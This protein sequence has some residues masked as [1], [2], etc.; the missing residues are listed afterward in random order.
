MH[1]NASTLNVQKMD[2]HILAGCLISPTA[3]R[4]TQMMTSDEVLSGMDVS[5]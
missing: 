4:A 2:F 5:T 3:S 1:Q